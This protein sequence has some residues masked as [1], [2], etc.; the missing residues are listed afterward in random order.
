MRS[1]RATRGCAA[2]GLAVLL[3]A[4]AAVAAE[5]VVVHLKS[6][7]KITARL[8]AE[9]DEWVTLAT[10]DG[11]IKLA[12]KSIRAIERPDPQGRHPSDRA[13]VHRP[14]VVRPPEQ[15]LTAGELKPWPEEDEK[16]IEGFLDRFFAATDEAQRRKAFAELERT[17]L[18]R[19][20]D[21]LERMRQTAKGKKGVHKHVPV[22][23]RKGA[24]RGWYNLA[25]PGDYSPTKAWPLVLALHGM[26]SD[27]DNLVSWYSRYFPKRGYIVL[28]PTTIH[29]SSFW[30]APAEKRELLKLLQHIARQY[31]IDYTRIYC[32]GGSGG[33]IGTWH[34]LTT[35]PELFVGGI[36]FSAAGTIFDKRLAR[37]KDVPFYVHHGT[38]DY[39]P[40]GSV[41]RAIAVAKQ[42]GANKIEFYISK[43]TGHTPPG[44]DWNRAFDWLAM[45]P[46]RETSARY[47]LE[48]AEGALPV[49][50]PKYLPF[51]VDPERDA[52]AKIYA[53]YKGKVARWAFPSELPYDDLIDGLVKVSQIVD[54]ACDVK[55][56]RAEIHKVAEAVRKKAGEGTEPLDRLYALNEVFF[57][58]RGFARDGS[59]PSGENPEGMVVSRVLMTRTG[60]TFTVAGIYAAVAHQL[61][62]KVY[63]V[64]TPY[65]AWVR[66]GDGATWLNIEMTEAGG[67]F[68][69]AVYKVGY[70]LE[71]LPTASSLTDRGVAELLAC[72]V[73]ALGQMC[74]RAGDKERAKAAAALA[75][76]LDGRC[77]IALLLTALAQRDDGKAGDAVKTIGQVTQAWP[78]Y[79]EPRLVE[80]DVYIAA[81]SRKSAVEAFRKGVR[82]HIKPY[83]AQAAYN[84]ELYYRIAEIY[85]EMTRAAMETRKPSLLSWSRKFNDAIMHCLKHN[86]H[87]PKARK[88]LVEMG[89]RVR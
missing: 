14:R 55:A 59:D 8:V 86:P 30:P 6:G 11:E 37:L 64:A 22:P 51:A 80:G 3:W 88:L 74:R 16:R 32:S 13:I 58:E 89:G 72:Q 25:I 79:A 60:N 85:A 70:G 28:F 78:S 35:L 34:W 45:L 68:E 54:P 5:T 26:P 52:L 87:H 33:G 42:Y 24:K 82:A 1:P 44:R 63:P 71:T 10:T 29:R 46:P 81:G 66:C 19:R 27:G 61:G 47:L 39:I 40:I 67:E 17:R 18:S 38:K 4:C 20:F 12:R 77:Y 31:R 49:G 2:L 57:H 41:Q 75:L 76:K 50:Y 62:L 84:A 73:A 7:A 9:D 83:G 56:A 69:N 21:E 36:S 15:P 43:G 48:S 53:S 65:H 23:W